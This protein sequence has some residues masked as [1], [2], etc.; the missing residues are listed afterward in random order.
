MVVVCALFR[1]NPDRKANEIGAR[2]YP[3]APPSQS[4]ATTTGIAP[5]SCRVQIG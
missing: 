3:Q 4:A 1:S 5:A 2:P